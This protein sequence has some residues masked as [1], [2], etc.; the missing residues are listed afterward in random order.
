MRLIAKAAAAALIA[1]G[2]AVASADV[3]LEGA[4]ATF[5]QPLY[6]RWV[7]EYQ[8]LHPDVKIDYQGIGSGGGIKAITEKTVDFAGS[9]APLSKS[10]IANLG[11]ADK[12]V[13]IPSCSG[14][15]VPA[16]NVPGVN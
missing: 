15:V 13:E 10:E 3:R 14:G 8:K 4:G 12:V 7:G 1:L 2:A 5:P 11:G 6:E 9:D 16:Y